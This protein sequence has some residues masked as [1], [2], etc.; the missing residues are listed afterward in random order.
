MVEETDFADPFPAGLLHI[1]AELVW[2][3]VKAEPAVKAPE[4]AVA[5]PTLIVGVCPVL[6]V[7]TPSK[8]HPAST[9]LAANVLRRL[10]L[11]INAAHRATKNMTIVKGTKRDLDADRGVD[12]D[13]DIPLKRA[14]AVILV[15]VVV[16]RH[17]RRVGSKLFS[18]RSRT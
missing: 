13:L 6:V 11:N 17:R 7:V 12:L 14:I 10:G 16:G 15:R 8:P 18:F 2:N 3:P 9:V 5:E 4:S 1:V